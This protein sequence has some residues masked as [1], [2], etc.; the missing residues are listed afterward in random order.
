MKFILIEYFGINLFFHID[1]PAKV[2]AGEGLFVLPGKDAY[3]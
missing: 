1:H 2:I 3:Q